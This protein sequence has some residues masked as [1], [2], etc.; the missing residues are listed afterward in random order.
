MTR[1]DDSIQQVLSARR[2]EPS[3]A[4]STLRFLWRLIR[5]RGAGIG[6]GLI[7][8]SAVCAIGAPLVAPY[9]PA[10]ID[11]NALLADP[12]SAHV[13][14]TDQLG[15]DMLSRLIY[16]ARISMIVGLISVAVA[17]GIG[18]PIGLTAGYAGG[19][20]DSVLM[21]IMDGLIA[22]PAL[23]LALALIAALGSSLTNV[24]IALGVVAV[25]TYA[26]ISR[27]QVLAL[28]SQDFVLAAR[29][30]GA[31]PVRIIARHILPNA[32]A[33]LI[34][35]ATFGFAGAIVAEAS[36][37]FLGL[38]VRPPTATWGNLLLDGFGF[39][40]L[41]PLLSIAPGTAIFLLVLSF[42]FLGDALRD[43]LDPRLRGVV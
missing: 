18:V 31:S 20:L 34:I 22:F 10:K 1:A 16:G 8:L 3:R 9:N 19:L 13:L 6:L 39:L 26:R 30:V 33:P 36:L 21:R 40:R 28:K 38:G 2:A 25:P 14:G 4:R 27:A 15:R 29:L 37:S 17:A 23:V 7:V 32:V 42:N 12:R 43:L 41:K 24:M 11:I 35:V 5:V